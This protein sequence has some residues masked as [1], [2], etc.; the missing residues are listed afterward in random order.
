MS[1]NDKTQAGRNRRGG[2]NLGSTGRAFRDSL[3]GTIKANRNDDDST[4]KGNRSSANDLR[5]VEQN[6]EATIKK[7]LGNRNAVHVTNDNKWPDYFELEGKRYKNE[8]ILSNSSGEAI[9]FKVSREGKIFALKI[10]YYD[11][12]HRPNHQVLEKVKQLASSGL[13]INII[14]H[15]EWSN[16]LLPGEKND[17]SLT[18]FCE[19]GTLDNV[20][21]TGNEQKLTEVAVKIGAAIDFLSKKGILHRDIKPSNFFFADKEQTKVILADFGISMECPPGGIVEIDEMRSPVYAAPEF[22]ANVPGQP[23][24]VGVESDYFSLGVSLLALWMGKAKLTANESQLLRSKLNETLPMPR[25]MSP[26][27]V[28]LIKAL[29]RVK[30]N[31]RATFSDIRRWAQGENLDNNS[32]PALNTDF[33]IVFNQARN[34][35]ANSPAELAAYLIK[36]KDLGKRYLYSGRIT[37]WLEE[38]GRNEV[39]VNV[40]EIVEKIYPQ[41]QEAG[42]MTVVYMLDPAMEYV[43][44]DGKQLKDPYDISLHIVSHLAEMA[45]EIVKPDSN[46]TIYMRALGLGEIMNDVQDYFKKNSQSNTNNG[47]VLTHA[48][49]YYLQLTNP[50]GAILLQD[51]G[52]P[53]WADTIQEVLDVLSHTGSISEYNRMLLKSPAFIIWLADKNPALAG[54]IRMLQDNVSDDVDSL[55]YNSDSAYRIAYELDPNVGLNFIT[56]PKNPKRIY[57][58]KEVGEN[59]GAMLLDFQKGK[60]DSDMFTT[61]FEEM[62]DSHIGDYLRSRG[63][64]YMN[65]LKWNRYCLDTTNNENSHK[66]GPYNIYIGAYKSVAGFIDGAPS[67][68]IGGKTLNSLDELKKIS[69]KDIK[70][71]L[72]NDNIENSFMESDEPRAWLDFWLTIFFQENPKLDLSKKF[73]YEKKAAEYTE[74][75]HSLNPDDYYAKRYYSALKT[76]D[77]SSGK[78]AFGK[79]K[80]KFYIWFFSLAAGLP[81][82]FMLI[83]GWIFHMPESNP[84]TGHYWDTFGICAISLFLGFIGLVYGDKGSAWF[85]T[86]IWGGVIG[87]FIVSLVLWA[88]MWIFPKVIY[89]LVFLVVGGMSLY[90]LFLLVKKNYIRNKGVDV[91][92]KEFEYRQL[93]ALHFAYHDLNDTIN[94]VVTRYSD[95][96][97]GSAL[98]GPSLLRSAGFSWMAVTWMFAIL[99]FMFTPT[100]SGARSWG[101]PKIKLSEQEKS[102]WVMGTWDATYTEGKTRIVCYVDSISPH[103]TIFGSMVIAGQKTVPASGRVWTVN[104]SVP[105]RFFFHPTSEFEGRRTLY[106]QYNNESQTF[107]GTYRDR[108]GEPHAVNIQFA[109]VITVN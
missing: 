37:R 77:K 52:K 108:N 2:F 6:I 4:V 93:D 11:P 95:S 68:Y 43:A 28:S 48:A 5:P 88:G 3:N 1:D 39:A 73:T 72:S 105:Q 67:Y 49:L 100:L 106:V 104:D 8:G 85:I 81:A 56:D 90:W 44:P 103:A 53:V 21:L 35:V 71:A 10:Y 62:D 98:G 101:H 27:M 9:I 66:S 33:R 20:V 16:P 97:S 36:D 19:G 22:Y 13:V 96:M 55:Y 34:E 65:F 63:Q 38:S 57:T 70:A 25:D 74:Y 54:K 61:L 59:I 92:G 32:L 26:H 40:E 60:Y 75:L 24:Q 94:N 64:S 15:G 46:L 78:I 7:D 82:L 31:E 14:S 79:I 99:W 109:P 76:I 17:Y 29:T 51:A 107:E 41:N 58:V 80:M 87:G 45:G 12:D 83:F 42:L 69:K 86:G 91:T 89:F 102:A 30:P 23:A 84:V 47:L 18:E 50:G